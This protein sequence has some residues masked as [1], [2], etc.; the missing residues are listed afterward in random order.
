MSGRLVI[1]SKKGY[2]PWKR[3]NVERVLRDER[4]AREK[5]AQQEDA[6]QGNAPAWKKLKA[7]SESQQQERFSLFEQEEQQGAQDFVQ[8]S[9]AK[10]TPG[11]LPVYL[12][13]SSKRRKDGSRKDPFYLHLPHNDSKETEQREDARKSAMDPMRAYHRKERSKDDNT[14][15]LSATRRRREAESAKDNESLRHKKKRHKKRKHEKKTTTTELQELRERRLQREQAEQKRQDSIR[16]TPSSTYNERFF[17][18]LA[19]R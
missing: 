2:C 6:A 15:K 3:E 7:S 18:E 11:I 10:V 16:T 5:A 8:G 9:K 12:D 14:K 1:S 13:S 17:P 4:L 19:R